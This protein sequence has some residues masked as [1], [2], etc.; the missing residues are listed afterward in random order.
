MKILPEKTDTIIV[1]NVKNKK[2]IYLIFNN[3]QKILL[4]LLLH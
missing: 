3:I 4:K 2:I 1:K